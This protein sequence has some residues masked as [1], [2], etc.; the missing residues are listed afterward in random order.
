M[1]QC[2]RISRSMGLC[3]KLEI[4]IS[5]TAMTLFSH[6]STLPLEALKY[7]YFFN[8]KIIVIVKTVHILVRQ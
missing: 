5:L 2:D 8:L 3:E 6:F 7:F 1:N 4:H